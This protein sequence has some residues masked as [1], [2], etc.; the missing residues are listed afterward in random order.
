MKLNNKGQALVAFVIILPVI[1]IIM[2]IIIDIG[3]MGVE[4]RKVTN[5]MKEAIEYGLKHDS[6]EEQIKDMIDKNIKY[7]SIDIKS[8]DDIHISLEY[9]Y[10]QIFGF[11]NKKN[12]QIK[13]HGYKENE[14][15]K[16][17]EE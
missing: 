8:N 16:I 1:L 4:K 10:K 9:E 17:E 3:L 12:I 7:K 11:I 5:V 13:Y 14:R 15:I 2:A 6:T